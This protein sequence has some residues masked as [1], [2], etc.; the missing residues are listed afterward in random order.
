[1]TF[2]YIFRI[3]GT[4]E[5]R[6]YL[7]LDPKTMEL[8]AID[9]N[10]PADWTELGFE[11][12]PN[13]PLSCEKAPHC[14]VALNLQGPIHL[15]SSELSYSP[16]ELE[17]HVRE[18]VYRVETTLQKAFSSLIG[19]IMVSSGCP[20]LDR[21]RPLVRH[22]LPVATMEETKF[23]VIGMYLLGQYLRHKAGGE[24]DWDLRDL[25]K[26]Y[27]E[28]QVVN[29]AFVRRLHR[30][31]EKDAGLNAVVVLNYL[32]DFVPFAID[33]GMMEELEGLY[34]GWLD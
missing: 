22:H 12:C 32:A 17:V 13:C 34:S 6:I 1:M 21:L 29:K 25:V 2:D 33:E 15:F 18:R 8:S 27:D 24:A 10:D 14:P 16:V 7:E 11:Q 31:V 23:R 19:I 3:E 20:A 4:A 28:I 9:D 5:K 30:A 26:I